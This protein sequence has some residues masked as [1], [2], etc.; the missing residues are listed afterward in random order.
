MIEQLKTVLLVLLVA[1]SAF[2][3]WQIWTYQPHYDYI[4]PT[5]Y[6]I[7]E[8]LAQRK[9]MNELVRPELI[10][11]HYGEQSHTVSYPEMLQYRILH[12][13][14]SNWYFYNF[15][16]VE[17]EDYGTWQSQIE[18]NEGIEFVF[19]TGLPL[20]LIQDI[21]QIRTE[22][23]TLPL[24]NRIWIFEDM[25]NEEVFAM[26]IS[27]DDQQL[28]QARTSISLSELKN[29]LAL[30]ESRPDYRAVTF[31]EPQEEEV[32]SIYYLPTS[33]VEMT[34]YRYFY[35]RIPVENMIQYLFVDPT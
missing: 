19:Q 35:Q 24:I 13:Q 28:V 17:Q 11:Y 33:P 14:M 30:G 29:Y 20:Q 4:N 2:L 18:E 10:I 8:G 23:V 34:E 5:E 3:T 12:G 27:E 7:H 6:V 9:E 31:S 32:Y 1:S 15:R 26:F 22:N 25:N 16:Q 21:F